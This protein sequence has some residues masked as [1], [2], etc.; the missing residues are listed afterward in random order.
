LAPIGITLVALGA[1]G[2]AL[3]TKRHEVWRKWARSNG[4]ARAQLT[5]S[6]WATR[7][8]M[9]FGIARRF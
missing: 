9:G 5:P 6:G 3:G 2:I 7:E 1:T 4:L 8:G